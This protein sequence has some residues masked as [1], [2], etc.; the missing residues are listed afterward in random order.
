MPRHRI[1]LGQIFYG[2]SL[3]INYN[4]PTDDPRTPDIIVTPNV[5]VTYS[6]SSQSRK[7]TAVSRMTTPM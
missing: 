7:S 4:D 1:G 5:G 6:G 2:P 3:A